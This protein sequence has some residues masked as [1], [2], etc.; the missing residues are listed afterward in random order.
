MLP[1][2]QKSASVCLHSSFR[3]HYVATIES[4]GFESSFCFKQPS[5][6]YK[7]ISTKQ[8][9]IRCSMCLWAYEGSW[10]CSCSST[11]ITMTLVAWRWKSFTSETWSHGEAWSTCHPALPPAVHT[12]KEQQMHGA[13]HHRRTAAERRAWSGKRVIFNFLL[14]NCLLFKFFA[15][16]APSMNLIFSSHLLYYLFH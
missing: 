12:S 15:Q 5:E 13:H 2:H 10:F 7:L 4:E 9:L 16:R 6:A 14:L 11:C 3:L 8:A 1:R